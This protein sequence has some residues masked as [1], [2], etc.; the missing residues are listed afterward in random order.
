MR[1][2]LRT[3]WRI[4]T[5]PFRL[6]FWIIQKIF[7]WIGNVFQDVRALFV[8]EP[9]DSTLTDALT[10]AVQN[11]LGLL[12]HLNSLRIHLFRATVVL[13][14]TT[15]I[16]F[17]FSNQVLG[18]LAEPV[19]GIEKLVAI[20][21]T[22]PIGI[23]MRVSLLT[24][25]AVALPYIVLELLLF[26]APGLKRYERRIGL[27]AIPAVAVLFLSGMAFTFYVILEPA[28]KFLTSFIFE[29][30]LQPA[31]YYPFVTSLLFWI[32][33]AFEFPLV[34]YVIVTWGLVRPRVLLEQSRIAV[35]L[36]AV[37]AAAITP[38]IDPIN[39]FLVWGPLVGLYFLGVG[40]AFIAQRRRDRRLEA[41]SQSQPAA[42]GD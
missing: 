29:T 6:V 5:A 8:E 7:S 39:M 13:F 24:G 42:D 32:G 35:V 10:K 19:G 12:E 1:N 30:N 37:A 41:N 40:L 28:L 38:T 17:A 34:I 27:V 11:P 20:G 33:L 22:E 26:A 36:L 25:F 21:V 3:F 18:F 9:D 15:A 16:S 14:I 2:Q 23:F 4:I 31:S